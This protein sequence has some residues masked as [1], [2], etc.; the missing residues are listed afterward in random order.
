MNLVRKHELVAR[1]EGVYDHLAGTQDHQAKL[2][3]QESSMIARLSRIRLTRPRGLNL[4][5]KRESQAKLLLPV[6]RLSLSL[7]RRSSLRTCLFLR[8]SISRP[9]LDAIPVFDAHNAT[10]EALTKLP[11]RARHVLELIPQVPVSDS[12]CRMCVCLGRTCHRASSVDPCE[13]CILYGRPCS[14][15]LEGVK[16]KGMY[17][18]EVQNNPGRENDKIWEI[19]R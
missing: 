19:L 9:S 16:R 15:N 11:D 2:H 18:D 5:I 10:E 7:V 3:L 1:A 4:W 8:I 17:S 12:P 14:S 13:S 6:Q